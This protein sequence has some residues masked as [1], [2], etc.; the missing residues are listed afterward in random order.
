MSSATN[1]KSVQQAKKR[2]QKFLKTLDKV[3][4]EVLEAEAPKLYFQII[5]ETP[6]ATGK[7]ERSV[8][9]S[10]SKNMR[11]RVSLNAS[12]SAKS[13]QGYDYSGRQHEDTSLHHTKGKAH[14]ISDPFNRAV[15]R[16]KARL[17][18]E[19]KYDA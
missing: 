1:A 17:R 3:P 6:V 19:V 14:F 4:V 16:I 9:V 5:A 11:D 7:L 10:V 13:S 12:A 15:R 8:R 18:R 2:L